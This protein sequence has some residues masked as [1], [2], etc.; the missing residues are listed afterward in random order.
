M[1][2][3]KRGM[4]GIMRKRRVA[5]LTVAALCAA[6][7]LG[8]AGANMY[9]FAA[10]DRSTQGEE[11]GSSEGNSRTEA[12]NRETYHAA[13]GKVSK[14]ET[15]YVLADA[16]GDTRKIIVS[17]WLR[18]G[19]G[20][21]KLKDVSELANIENVNGEEGFVLEADNVMAW[22]ANGRDIYYQG[23][24]EKNPPIGIAVTYKLDGKEISPEELAGK[25]GRV[26]I[27]FDYTNEQYEYVE[28]DGIRTKVYVP[29]VVMTGLL[30]DNEAFTNV[31]ISG[32]RLVNDGGRTAVVGFALPGLRENL[33]I[34]PDK[35]DIPDYF[36]VTADVRGF[37][38]GM[39]ATVA[40]NALFNETDLEDRDI[41]GK[42]DESLEELTDAMEQLKSGSLALY[43]GLCT[44]L[45][46]SGG[47]I[48][49]IDRLNDGASQLRT[50]IGTLDEGAAE[51]QDGTARLQAGL[52]TL[53]ARSGELNN[54]ARQVFD[55]LLA[56]AGTQLAAA[57]LN[58]PAMSVENYAEVLNG[59]IA[60]MDGDA[61][62]QQAYGQ[63]SAA[64]EA[65]REEV[66]AAVTATVRENVASNVAA[67]VREQVTE[68]VKAGAEAEVISAVL[69][70][71]NMTKEQYD[72][73]LAGGLIDEQTRAALESAVSSQMASDVVQKE[74]ADTVDA[75]MASAEVKAILDENIDRQMAGEEIKGVI[76]SN[77]EAQVQKLIS[78][79]MSGETVQGQLA[80]ASEG[81]KSVIALKASLDSYNTF[82]LGL[83][84]YTAGVAQAAGGA[85]ELKGGIDELRSGTGRLY[86]G[87]SELCDGIQTMKDAAPALTDGI[88]QLRDGALELFDGLCRFD[89]EGVR[90][91][92]EA[93]D[94]DLHGLEERL[95]ATVE[96]SKNYQSFSGIH[97]GMEGQVKFIYRT[98][99]IE[100]KE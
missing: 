2:R 68:Q 42:L 56:T 24:T 10:D 21:D 20:V 87:S 92:A 8:G 26:T 61:I 12:A 73:A 46:K 51:L 75:Q 91:L 47:L 50:G 98:D 18:N 81:A 5:G 69:Q 79:N 74:I 64:V 7:T 60:S 54:G 33:N 23:S 78:E 16:K 82:Y 90:K 85:G 94:G 40:T 57:G 77:T 38:L 3:R 88:I 34:G 80:A 29:F 28:I 36:E 66:K 84:A 22:D 45:E 35:L 17:D 100:A 27:R 89:E 95:K 39:T 30:L 6:L 41:T 55:T 86:S 67:A 15:V 19:E 14:E 52:A 62:Y 53:N 31:E 43:D 25:S 4:N 44:L 9:T 97:D 70:A 76:A 48:D 72:E 13:D 58:V 1:M 32:G 71:M 93:V 96:V 63:V 99:S 65:R 37:E 59:I 11:I 49:G 83:Q